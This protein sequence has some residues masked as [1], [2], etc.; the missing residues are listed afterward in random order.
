MSI[1]L[2]GSAGQSH[3][4]PVYRK[5]SIHQPRSA[6]LSTEIF[7]DRPAKDSWSMDTLVTASVLK[8]V[9]YILLKINCGDFLLKKVVQLYI[10][11]YEFIHSFLNS[12]F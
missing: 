11:V 3:K 5:L 6:G 2:P 7:V 8:F 4:V 9:S 1:D 12:Q 10:E